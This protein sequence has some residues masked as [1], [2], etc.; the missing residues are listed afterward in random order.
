MITDK[1]TGKLYVGSATANDGMLLSR[2]S[3]YVQNGHGG[4]IELKI[5]VNK[6]DL[7]ISKRIFNTRYW[8][9]IMQKLTMNTSKQENGIGKSIMYA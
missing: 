8:K 5:I 1:A 6:K 2:W 4:N 9:T 3:S 7:S